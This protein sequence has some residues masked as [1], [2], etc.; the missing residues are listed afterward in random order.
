M[1]IY[2]LPDPPLPDLPPIPPAPPSAEQ[3]GDGARY[4]VVPGAVLAADATLRDEFAAA[5]L[6]GLLAWSP[7]E[8]ETQLVPLAAARQA[9]MMADAM[10]YIR[11]QPPQWSFPTTAVTA[12]QPTEPAAPRDD[13]IP[14]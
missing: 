3:L 11:S 9:Y 8:A 12:P 4:H 13:S 1:N 7:V 10:M 5:A 14:F 2:D 6:T